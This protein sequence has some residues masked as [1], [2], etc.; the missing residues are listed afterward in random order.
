MKLKRAKKTV[1]IKKNERVA[2]AG[3]AIS[4]KHR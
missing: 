1:T 4:G 2:V 3:D